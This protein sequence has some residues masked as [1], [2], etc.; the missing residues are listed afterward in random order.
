MLEDIE[1]RIKQ[2]GG[3]ESYAAGLGLSKD[4]VRTVLEGKRLPSDVMIADL[5][6]Y[7]YRVYCRTIG[8]PNG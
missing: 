1:Y 8:K 7:K 2:A 4:F 5:G 6:A 3:I